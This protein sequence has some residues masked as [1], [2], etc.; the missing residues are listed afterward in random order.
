M[1]KLDILTNGILDFFL[2]EI[3]VFL[4]N[5]IPSSKEEP[6]VHFMAGPTFGYK[7]FYLS[8]GAFFYIYNNTVSIEE[9]SFYVRTGAN[10][11]SWQWG[12]GKGGMDIG[13]EF[14][15]TFYIPNPENGLIMLLG[16][17]FNLIKLNV[18]V[19]YFLPM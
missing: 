10:F 4:E 9:I 2:A 13:L 11:S 16:T 8:G 18:G 6:I 7:N 3:F 19:S 1:N 12:R 14:S 15:P 5:I 17:M